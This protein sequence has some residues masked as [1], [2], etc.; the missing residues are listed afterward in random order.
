MKIEADHA[1]FLAGVRHGVTLGT[2]ICIHVENMDHANWRQIM[3]PEEHLETQLGRTHPVTIPR[4]GH[5]DLV[6]LAKYGHTDIRN[7]LERASARETV[8]RVAVGAVCR[9]ILEELKVT[10]RGRV[11]RIGEVE[12]MAPRDYTRP[13]SID[14]DEVETSTVAC[15]DHVVAGEMRAHIDAARD[16]GESLGG[17]F[18]VWCLG[19]CPGIGGYARATDRLDGRL[20]G[21]L[22]SI[23]AVKGA[24]VGPAF[25][26]AGFFGSQVH[27]AFYVEETVSGKFA[28]RKTNRAGGLEGGMT[29]GMPLI[30]R[31]AMKPIPTLTSPLPSV[32]L[33]TLTPA[34]AHV[35]R[36]DVCAVP[37]AQVVGEAVVATVLAAAYLEKFGGDSM[38]ELL[39]AVDRYENTLASRGLW[40]RS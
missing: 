35:E 25:Q 7:V 3:S 12:T 20:L 14:W 16:R 24:E 21:A 1:T 27:D 10:I 40:R 30:L 5:A 6:G 4:P 36:S 22:G 19:L 29:T 15:E 28:A 18:E 39:S 38:V 37:A 32:D 23:P 8:G 34:S 9:R 11:V 17:V 33:E 13:E 31:A 26:N 2:P